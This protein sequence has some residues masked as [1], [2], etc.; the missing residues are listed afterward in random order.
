M[1]TRSDHRV[2]L[3]PRGPLLQRREEVVGVLGADTH[4]ASRLF[5]D[6]DR[7]RERVEP[8]SMSDAYQ[9]GS[10][11]P[12]GVYA[13]LAEEDECARAAEVVAAVGESGAVR[14]Y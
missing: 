7:V 5:L 12:A 14:G 3:P 11:R 6:E 9:C 10:F 8:D 2:L 13:V 4:A 1:C